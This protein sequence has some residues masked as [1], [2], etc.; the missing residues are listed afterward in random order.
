MAGAVQCLAG[1]SAGCSGRTPLRNRGRRE[2]C[3]AVRIATAPRGVR[4][5]LDDP[6]AAAATAAKVVFEPQLDPKLAIAAVAGATPFVVAAVL[7]SQRIA[8]QLNCLLCRGTG[9]VL[10]GRFYRRCNACGGFLP[11]QSWRRF[12]TG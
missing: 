3:G 5:V 2:P 9:L 10:K 1:L 11:F 12:F 6:S 4:C 8:A 7:F